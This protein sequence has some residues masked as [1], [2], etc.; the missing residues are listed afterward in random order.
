MLCFYFFRLLLDLGANIDATD[1]LGQKPI[2]VAA[3]NNFS[4]VAK[5]FL[6]RHPVLVTATS[7][8]GNTCAHIAAM[9]GSVRV[10][11]ELM[12]FDRNGVISA[13]NKITDSTPLQLA[14]EG[15]HAEV[16]PT[17]SSI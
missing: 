13:R 3:Q 9:Q 12:K 10:I 5:L 6:Q 2:H 15:G 7:K 17:D 16:K 4:D 11:E 1:D 14:A 8:D